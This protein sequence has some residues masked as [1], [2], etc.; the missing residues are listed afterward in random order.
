L[1]R[2]RDDEQP[3]AVLFYL[4][5]LMGLSGILDCEIM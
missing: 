5:V 1:R 4:R 2:S 3:L